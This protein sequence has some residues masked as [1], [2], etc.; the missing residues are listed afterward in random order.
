MLMKFKQL[1]IVKGILSIVAVIGCATIDSDVHI[2][3]DGS[4]TWDAT[5]KS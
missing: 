5:V 3:R 2:N 1:G 4:G